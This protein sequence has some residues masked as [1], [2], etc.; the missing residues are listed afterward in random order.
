M[1]LITLHL[2]TNDA[3]QSRNFALNPRQG[4]K[5]S[6]FRNAQTPEA[7]ADR[8]LYKITQYLLHLAQVADLRTIMHKVG[9]QLFVFF[10]LTRNR[11]GNTLSKCW[12]DLGSRVLLFAEHP[13]SFSDI[14][15]KSKTWMRTRFL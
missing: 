6:P 14:L 13:L 12:L 9:F 2:F 8:E 4:L 15:R 7:V 1:P 10:V 3:L 11:I 5:I